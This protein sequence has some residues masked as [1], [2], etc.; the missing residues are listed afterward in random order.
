MTYRSSLI[1]IVQLISAAAAVA[2]ALPWRRGRGGYLAVAA[3]VV[4]QSDSWH[5]QSKSY[6]PSKRRL[7]ARVAHDAPQQL[8]LSYPPYILQITVACADE[9]AALLF[10]SAASFTQPHQLQQQRQHP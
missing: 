9:R 4:R 7:R 8:F 6:T 5:C 2:A 1:S 10:A 3:G